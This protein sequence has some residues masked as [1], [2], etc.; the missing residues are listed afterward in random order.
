M[1]KSHIEKS[2]E[3]LRGSILLILYEIKKKRVIE[4]K[5]DT[6]KAKKAVATLTS[7]RGELK[8]IGQSIGNYESVEFKRLELK[9]RILK[10][11]KEMQ[12]EP[13][14]K[15]K[16]KAIIQKLKCMKTDLEN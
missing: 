2:R 16:V 6:L 14:L 11:I 13:Y 4:L 10:L 8:E 1:A 5:K 7:W 3:K 12:N 15:E 9:G